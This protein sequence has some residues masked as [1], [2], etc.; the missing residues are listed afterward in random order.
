MKKVVLLDFDGVVLRNRMADVQVA[1][2]ASIYTVQQ[3]NKHKFSRHYR[4]IVDTSLGSDVCYNMYK[5]YG[6]TVLGLKDIGVKTCHLKDYNQMI[7]DTLD[8]AVLR[9]NN[10]D[11]NDV[12][13]VI[14]YCLESDYDIFM[15]SNAPWKW[16]SNMLKD[17]KDILDVVKDVRQVL[18][19]DEDN[20][21]YLKP[22]Q[23]IYDVI[24][25]HFKD[26]NI[27]FIDD[28]IGNIKPVIHN[29]TWTNIVLSS[30]EKQISN[31]LYFV[32]DL[33]K[34]IDII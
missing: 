15:F 2:R 23:L 12:K 9:K 19:L 14:N 25:S 8:Y 6:H 11:F 28:N 32:D 20:E 7:Y 29:I 1:K 31:Q 30:I 33:E 24:N 13:T 5:G 21:Q 34:V 4:R 17:N 27:I 16:I 10:N 26:R 18:K 22:Y 3:L